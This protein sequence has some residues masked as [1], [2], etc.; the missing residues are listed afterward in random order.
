MGGGAAPRGRMDR[1]AGSSVWREWQ[2]WYGL[3][4]QRPCAERSPLQGYDDEE[5][6]HRVNRP[7]VGERPVRHWIQWNWLSDHRHP[8]RAY[9]LGPRRPVCPAEFP[10]RHGRLLPFEAEPLPVC[11]QT[12]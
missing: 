1:R 7:G 4:L 11:E 8:T 5:R 12:P 9:R 2:F 6:R 10:N 3:V